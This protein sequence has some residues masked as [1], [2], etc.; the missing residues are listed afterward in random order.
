VGTYTNV[1][2][3]L[4]SFSVAQPSGR[5]CFYC[6][7]ELGE[8]ER[9]KCRDRVFNHD[10]DDAA[11]QASN[12]P[13]PKTEYVGSADNIPGYAHR[14]D[15]AW[16]PKQRR[17]RRPFNMR[18][19]MSGLWRFFAF[20]ADEMARALHPEWRLTH[21][22]WILLTTCLAGIHYASLNRQ[23]TRMFD[24]ETPTAAFGRR[25]LYWLTGSGLVAIIILLFTLSLWLV[26]RY[27]YRQRALPYT[28]TLAVGL[29]AWKYAVLFFL[30]ALP[31][32]YTS[33]FA[34]SFVLSVMGLV[35]S[36]VV[37]AHQVAK[38]THLDDNRMWQFIY[39]SII[40]FAGI[41]SATTAL[42]RMFNI[43]G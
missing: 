38:L 21:T 42:A 32:L 15:Q 41:L 12:E 30:L 6:G 27:I 31:S 25:M 36:I 40:V 26:A 5:I 19:A 18:Q 9:C 37:H 23:I 28:H 43:I 20:P 33:G 22:I 34:F 2:E 35:M 24:P 4:S 14:T 17:R 29:H 8:H 13:P 10:R 1:S 7:R 16:Q 11:S 39:L 3:R